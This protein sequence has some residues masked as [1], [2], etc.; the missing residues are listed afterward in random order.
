MSGSGTF[1]DQWIPDSRR[2][3]EHSSV[4]PFSPDHSELVSGE[5]GTAMKIWNLRDLDANEETFSGHS[6]Y[7]ISAVYSKDGSR[8]FTAGGDRALKVWDVRTRQEVLRL[9]GHTSAISCFALSPDERL[10]A[11]GDRYGTIRLWQAATKEEVAASNWLSI[12]HRSGPK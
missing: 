6:I 12:D 8:L 10:I 11:S 2:H 7:V 1:D 5:F 4:L 3:K 9:A